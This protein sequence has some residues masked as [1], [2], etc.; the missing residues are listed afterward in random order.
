MTLQRRVYHATER[1]VIRNIA[2]PH[3]LPFIFAG[4]RIALAR[5]L[6]GVIIAEMDVSLKGLGGLITNFG[7]SFETASLMAAIITSSMV[8]V[9]GTMFLEILRR[10]LTPWAAR[11]TALFEA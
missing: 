10:R 4:L 5:A 6:V 2:M 7:D 3:S 9:I 8:G 1:S 11:P